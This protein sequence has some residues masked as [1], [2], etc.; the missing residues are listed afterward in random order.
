MSQGKLSEQELQEI[1]ELAA[2]WGK[3]VA[4]RAAESGQPLDL[5]QMER[6][7][8][9]AGLTEGTLDPLLDQQAQALAPRQP[10]PDCDR[11]CDVAHQDRPPPSGKWTPPLSLYSGERGLLL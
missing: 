3:I 11:L 4:R 6:L 8:A 7:A 2:G 9:A 5:M 10:C 1:R